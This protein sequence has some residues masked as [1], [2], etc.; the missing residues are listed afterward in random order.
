MGRCGRAVRIS[1]LLDAGAEQLRVHG[2]ANDDLRFRPFRLQNPGHALQR[3]AGAVA[4]HPI[5]EPLSG[6]VVDD[7]QGGRARMEIRV[8]FVLE[9]TRHE[10]AVGMASSMVLATIPTARSAAGVMTTLAP[11]KRISFRRSTL[12]G[13]AMVNTSG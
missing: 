5:V 7:L 3:A 1:H 8:R 12:N 2:F 11:R 9:L 13:S 6:K 4:S 10:P